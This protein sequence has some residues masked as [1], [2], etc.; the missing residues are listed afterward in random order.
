MRHV[1]TSLVAAARAGS[2]AAWGTLYQNHKLA[3]RAVLLARAPVRDVDDLMQDVF[4]KALARL[5]T[6]RDD[7]AFSGWLMTIARNRATDALRGRTRDASTALPD[8]ASRFVPFAE[9]REVLNAIRALPDAFREPLLMRLVCGMSGP[10]IAERLD[11]TPGSVRV[12][13]HRGLKKLRH[14]LG[15]D[16]ERA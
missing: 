1:T 7:R 5:G 3:V 13:L 15:V 8:V 12:N 2:S 14:A 4:T 6:L 16:Q 10:E 11:M 9:A